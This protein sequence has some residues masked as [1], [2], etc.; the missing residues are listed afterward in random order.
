MRI[1]HVAIWSKEIEVLNS[2][3]FVKNEQDP[4]SGKVVGY[5][6]TGNKKSEGTY[7]NGVRDGLWTIWYNNGQRHSEKK[8]R[9][10]QRVG[11]WTPKENGVV[12]SEDQVIADVTLKVDGVAGLEEALL[13]VADLTRRVGS[14]PAADQNLDH[15][16]SH[17]R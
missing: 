17:N 2:I 4:Y 3:A 5:Y 9:E 6:N 1:E 14:L 13:A 7:K 12:E 10:G 15:L 11:I 8:L 16:T